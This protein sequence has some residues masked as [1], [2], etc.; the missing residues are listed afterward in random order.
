MDVL[1][2][3]DHLAKALVKY[4]DVPSGYLVAFDSFH[5]FQNEYSAN[6]YR[7]FAIL[8][9]VLENVSPGVIAP[10]KGFV[11]GGNHF[12]IFFDNEFPEL[13]QAFLHGVAITGYHETVILARLGLLFLF[14]KR[15]FDETGIN[16][17]TIRNLGIC[18]PLRNQIQLPVLSKSFQILFF[19]LINHYEILNLFGLLLFE[20]L[21]RFLLF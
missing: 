11:E 21:G 9:K 5:C 14:S 17:L 6:I 7:C 19:I 15:C 12:D 13:N 10:R 2:L 20:M 16:D 4:L 1:N 3:V 8:R 18:A